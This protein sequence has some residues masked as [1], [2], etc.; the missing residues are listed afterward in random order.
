MLYTDCFKMCAKC[1]FDSGI[2]SIDFEMQ[3]L[4][5][6]ARAGVL[7]VAGKEAYYGC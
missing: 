2:I 6:L 4:M 1:V 3:A 5:V 7:A